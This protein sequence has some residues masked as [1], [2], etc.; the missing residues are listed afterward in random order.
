MVQQV[1]A[2]LQSFFDSLP[3]AAAPEPAPPP[4]PA[5]AP[6]PYT[7]NPHIAWDRL[8]A[9]NRV[10]RGPVLF[11]GALLTSDGVGAAGA[12]FFDGMNASGRRLFRLNAPSGETKEV[13][14]TAPILLTVGLFIDVGANVE[15]VFA[16]FSPQWE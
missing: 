7:W 15:D 5:P 8:T 3:A 10:V 1:P 2:E 12:T 6:A 4:G 11:G 16:L 9:D 14:F 13:I